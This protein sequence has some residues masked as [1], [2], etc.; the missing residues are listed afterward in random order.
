MSE[1]SESRYSRQ[2]ATIQ[3]ELSKMQASSRIVTSPQELEEL[4]REIRQLTDRL[5]AAI[6]GQRVQ[7]SLDSEAGQEAE[8]ELIKKHPQRL[9]SEGK[10]TRHNSDLVRL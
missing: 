6:L 10:K 4:E 1:Q 2:I 9:K 7:G 8:Q 3:Q 5:A